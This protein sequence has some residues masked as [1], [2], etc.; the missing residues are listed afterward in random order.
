MLFA[1]KL[2]LHI[3]SF[4][5]FFEFSASEAVKKYLHRKLCCDLIMIIL[6]VA[7]EAW[8]SRN[9]VRY[10]DHHLFDTLK[11]W[12]FCK[13]H[14]T[15]RIGETSLNALFAQIMCAAADSPPNTPDRYSWL[16]LELSLRSV[17][18]IYL[19]LAF[20]KLRSCFL[21]T[22]SF[23]LQFTHLRYPF[24]FSEKYSGCL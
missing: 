1:C 18:F 14:K 17:S 16:S 2:W 11:V 19:S 24:V 10:R 3:Y 15:F 20:Q 21:W 12:G 8:T 4:H 13:I 5:S 9:L 23:S 22:H 6:T 7:P